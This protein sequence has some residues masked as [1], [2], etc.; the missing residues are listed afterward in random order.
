MEITHLTP[1]QRQA[2]AALISYDNQEQAASALGIEPGTFRCLLD[3]ARKQAGA[4]HNEEL[5]YRYTVEKIQ[6]EMLAHI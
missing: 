2:V 5:V 3:R 1:R 6:R 4:R